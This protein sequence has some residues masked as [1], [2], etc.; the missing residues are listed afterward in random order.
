[1]DPLNHALA[2]AQRVVEAGD[3]YAI[4]QGSTAFHEAVVATSTNDLMIRVM[5]A[6]GAD[7]VAVLP[8]IGVA[9]R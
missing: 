6:I 9:C 7:H 1:M 3:A 5:G 4:A 8:D 2:E